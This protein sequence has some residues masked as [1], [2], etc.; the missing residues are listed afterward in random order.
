M[1]WGAII[2]WVVLGLAALAAVSVTLYV[3]VVMLLFKL[4]QKHV[5][6]FLD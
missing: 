6:T 1:D 2:L 5:R 4:W 3:L